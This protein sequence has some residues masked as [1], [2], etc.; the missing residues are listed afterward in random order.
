MS[1][2]QETDPKTGKVFYRVDVTFTHADGRV[3][4]VKRVSPVQTRKGAEAFERK[5]RDSLAD[6]T[7]GKR[8]KEE[9]L[10]L[11]GFRE[12]YFKDHV[13]SLKASTRAG[14]AAIW[15]QHLLPA[16]GRTRVDQVTQDH[17]AKLATVMRDKKLSPKTVN[18]VLS[19][20]RKALET[21]ADWGLI[22]RSTVPRFKWAKVP[23]QKFD[24][25]TF[26]EAEAMIAACADDGL[27]RSMVPF[28]LHTGLRLGELRA[29]RWSDIDE[30]AKRVVVHRSDWQGIEAG[31]KSDNVRHVPLNSFS[32]GAIRALKRGKSDG[33]VFAGHGE[34]LTKEQCK[35][36]LW[37]TSDKAG[38][39]RRI[40]WHVLRH[41]FA[42][43]LVMRNVPL[44]T[45]QELM[46]H[47]TIEMTM[48]Y[49]HL[50]PGHLRG[51]VESLER[52]DDA[53]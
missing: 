12:R 42:S 24:F 52:P 48:R 8:R 4:R 21:A 35:W 38:I 31:T 13:A 51:A 41:S 34:Q 1:V 36:P 23:K 29:L 20:L 50:A 16:M 5:L 15:D 26:A 33:Y 3:Q 28:A 6:G 25:L 37:R 47:A 46:G 2:Y 11:E 45:V 22:E 30:A 9:T 44:R 10:T 43:H 17:L 39:G 40:G 49:S 27:W 18:N 19:C 53:Q 7:H 32:L 14:H